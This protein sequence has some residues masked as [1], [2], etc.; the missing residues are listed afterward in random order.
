MHIHSHAHNHH[1]HKY[2]MQCR[3]A[4]LKCFFKPIFYATYSSASTSLLNKL[5]FLS[6]II[7][8]VCTLPKLVS[9]MVSKFFSLLEVFS[10]HIMWERRVMQKLCNHTHEMLIQ[11]SPVRQDII[12]SKLLQR[13][14]FFISL[15]HLLL[16]SACV[17]FFIHELIKTLLRPGKGFYDDN[18]FIK[19]NKTWSHPKTLSQL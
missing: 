12:S 4:Y 7:Y 18:W 11:S 3:L 13:P 19:L 15:H 9:C 16:Q 1:Y 14:H 17:Q 10:C 6:G 2:H 5:I 8:S